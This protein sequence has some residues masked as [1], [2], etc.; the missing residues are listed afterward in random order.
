MGLILLKHRM[1]S[2]AIKI[3]EN[4]KLKKFD[5]FFKNKHFKTTNEILS[6]LNIDVYCIPGN[7]PHL[8]HKQLHQT[9]EQ[10]RCKIY[11]LS[12]F[13]PRPHMVQSTQ[14][15]FQSVTILRQL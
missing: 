15:N 12:D 6:Y 14:T 11:F 7:P 8:Q 13:L 2:M 9:L 3:F 4:Q 1:K 5:K 10:G